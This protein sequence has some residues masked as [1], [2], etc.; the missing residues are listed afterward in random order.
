MLIVEPFC[1]LLM[2]IVGEMLFNFLLGRAPN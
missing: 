2:G 1:E